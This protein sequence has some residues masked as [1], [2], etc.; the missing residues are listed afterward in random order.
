M[1]NT[2]CSTRIMRGIFCV[3]LA[4]SIAF[5][6]ALFPLPVQAAQTVEQLE[7][8]Y[9]KLEKQIKDN[10]KKLSQNAE[11]RV[12]TKDK[13]SSLESQ[14]SDLNA[15]IDILDQKISVLNSDIQGLNSHIQSLDAEIEGINAQITSTKIDIAMSETTIDMTYQKVLERMRMSYMMGA[16]SDLELLIGAQSLSDILTRQQ[17]LQ[18]AAEYDE[19]L[20]HSL[21]EDIDKLHEMNITLDAAMERVNLKKAEIEKQKKDLQAKQANVQSSANDLASKKYS[22]NVKRG[23]AVAMLRTLDKQSEEYKRMSKQLA[24]EKEKVAAEIDALI[25][26][27]GSS[28]GQEMAADI[29]NDGTLI[30]PLPYKNCYISAYYGQYP[31]GGE[32]HG[33]DICVRGGTEGK[34][35]VASADGTVISYGFN[36]WSMGNYIIID[37]GYGLF[38][39]YYHLQK[40]YV[41]KGDR[42]KQ[43]QVIGLAGHTGNTTGPHLHFEVRISRG[44]VITRVNPLKFVKMPG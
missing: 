39:A 4:V 32:H 21:E 23:D 2:D 40:L 42:V 25:A 31:S 33:L 8:K 24:A 18:N 5:A 43:G 36:H 41:E 13:I 14:I 11:N 3:I 38:T 30:W 22:V 10:E 20:V 7:A 34:N 16:S 28:Q 1:R 37:H 29:K 12:E 44:G 15:Q 27:Q 17:Y 6:S 35:V 26:A 9:D 19:A